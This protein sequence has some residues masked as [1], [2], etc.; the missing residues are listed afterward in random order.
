MILACPPYNVNELLVGTGV[1]PYVPTLAHSLVR[2]VDCRT[3][4]WLGPNQRQAAVR[5]LATLVLCML[6]AIKEGNRRNL[7]TLVGHL[8]GREGGPRL[9]S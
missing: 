5:A 8:G 7:P 6:C 9:P 3:E 1:P 4:V 2:C